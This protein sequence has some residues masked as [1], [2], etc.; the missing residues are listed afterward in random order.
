MPV[1]PHTLFTGDNLPIMRGMDSESVDLIYLDPPF[2]KKKDFIAPIGSKAEGAEFKDWWTMD[3]VKDEE[4]G[5]IGESYPPVSDLINT[6]GDISG[7]SHR[8]YLI[9]MAIRLIEMKRLLKPT[10]SIY[11][12]CDPT[13]SHWLKLLMDAIFDG[14]NFRNE[15]VWKRT[16]SRSDGKQ[17]GR[18]TDT[19]LFYTASK[20]FSWTPELTETPCVPPEKSDLTGPG[21]ST[22]ESG[23]EWNG[24]NPTSV[25]RC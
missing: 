17:W 2:N 4:I 14:K 21:I 5:E 13:M 7:E 1:N 9:V 16:T 20:K 3:D 10:G 11:L 19:I 18:V 6:A 24:Y 15:I 8:S 25:G 22:G 23:K 12:H